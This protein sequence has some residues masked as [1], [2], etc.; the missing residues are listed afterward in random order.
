MTCALPSDSD[1]LQRYRL[2]SR[3]RC[4]R[5]RFLSR[6]A[7]KR[8]IESTA[9]PF[10]H[11]LTEVKYHQT[12]MKGRNRISVKH[13]H[14]GFVPERYR[15]RRAHTGRCQTFREML[16]LQDVQVLSGLEIDPKYESSLA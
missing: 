7:T 4:L 12:N 8:Q 10:P 11:A 15:H 9:N 16:A 2:Q 1:K 14:S 13:Y 5:A 3:E 6:E